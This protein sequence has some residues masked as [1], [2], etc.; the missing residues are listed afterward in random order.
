MRRVAI[1][2]FYDADGIVDDYM[3]YLIKS[4][5]PFVERT[6]FVSNG[7]LQP[8]SLKKV[9]KIV[10]EIIERENKELDVGGYKA[11]LDYIGFDELKKYDEVILYNHTI[12]GPFYPFLEMFNEM[13][14]RNVDFWGITAHKAL[15]QAFFGGP[16][17]YHIQSHFIAIR[18]TIISK[19]IFEE[20]WRN[21][22]P[23]NSY[24]DSVQYHE[25]RFTKYFSDLGFKHS[26]YMD[27]NKFQSLHPILEQVDKCIEE[28]CPIIKR[29]SFFHD[30]IHVDCMA[31]NFPLALR[32]I[33]KTSDYDMELA[34]KNIVRTVKPR[35][36]TA[37]S[38]RLSIL[39]DK[40]N[41]N[42]N[43]KIKLKIG[44]FIH[45][46][47][48]NELDFIKKYISNIN[49]KFDLFISTSNEENAKIIKKYFKKNLC[50]KKLTIRIVEQNRGRDM[51]SLFITFR[52]ILLS[53][54]Y[55]VA[56]RLHSKKSPQCSASQSAYFIEHLFE[57]LLGSK[58]Y[59]DNL[60][61][62]FQKDPNLGLV[63][64]PIIHIG[65]GTL[66][67]SWYSNK[68]KVEEICKKLHINVPLDDNTPVAP[69]GTM[70]WFRPKALHKL[71]EYKWN[72]E[73]FN[74]EPNHVDGGLAHA[75]ERTIAY[76]THDAGYYSQ[77]VL[78]TT[79]APYNY[80]MLEYKL[81]KLMSYMPSPLAY[82]D[83][84]YLDLQKSGE[85][86]AQNTQMQVL[87][88][89]G[90]RKAYKNLRVALKI[91]RTEAIHSFIK[92]IKRLF[93]PK[94]RS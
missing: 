29:R 15:A 86:S 13:E 53:D 72:W 58:S 27:D 31:M 92:S 6:V 78:S 76:T 88:H 32:V 45:L 47:Y 80:V 54:K 64:P 91:Y 52:D 59:V 22:P 57:N 34:W 93:R 65:F 10:P 71:F 60:L 19:S 74:A 39:S 68:P 46:Y 12:F 30:P 17:P 2:F 5:K 21:L 61:N 11:G 44:V 43:R 37:N 56:C 83:I 7:K 4:L 85:V 84:K 77:H 3:I 87:H 18:N 82:E 75:L 81:Q 67:F 55:D 38:A 25:I 40:S 16:A 70:F 23:I 33:E 1:A 48:V 66:G 42:A 28:R 41:E 49:S 26:V 36:F 79:E 63:M 24:R 90:S 9:K 8:Q 50:Y 20:Y 35:E 89:I 62:L 69:Y 73:D 51:S 94:K 14:K